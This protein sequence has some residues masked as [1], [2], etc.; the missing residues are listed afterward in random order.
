ML[1]E[2]LLKYLGKIRRSVAELFEVFFHKDSTL[3]RVLHK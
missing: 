1:K 3:F 2:K